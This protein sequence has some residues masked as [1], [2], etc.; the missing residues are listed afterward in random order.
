M[1]QNVKNIEIQLNE[2]LAQGKYA[3]L[4]VINHSASEFILDFIFL[5]P[6]VP[7]SKVCSR[8]VMTPDNF[9]RLMLALKD[10]IDKFET[11]FGEIQL[12]GPIQAQAKTPE[13]D[14][15]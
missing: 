10:N 11:R 8:I 14:S 4:S 7:K 5:Q 13:V 2:E 15:E 1:N 6:G 9:K 3:N 12:H